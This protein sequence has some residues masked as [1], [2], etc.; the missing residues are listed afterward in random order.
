MLAVG[1]E[2]VLVLS[3]LRGLVEQARVEP[4]GRSPVPVVEHLEHD[5]SPPHGMALHYSPVTL[6][7]AGGC[8]SG[9]VFLS[10]SSSSPALL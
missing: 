8:D 10:S 3:G 9:S 4:G 5:C 7:S 2:V 1:G 6:P